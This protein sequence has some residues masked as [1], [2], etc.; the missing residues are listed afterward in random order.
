MGRIRVLLVISVAALVC[1]GA[2]SAVR[3]A[4]RSTDATTQEVTI[5]VSDGTKLAC[6][7]VLPDGNPPPG[8]WPG[9]GRAP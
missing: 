5:Q 2:A 9:A 3:A 8:G 1:A 4:T 6:G 7:L